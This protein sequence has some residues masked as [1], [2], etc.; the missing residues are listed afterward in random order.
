MKR[1]FF[2]FGIVLAIQLLSFEGFGQMTIRK[3]VIDPGH[4]G[5]DPGA[6]GRNSREKDIVLAVALKTGAYIEQYLDDVEV[7][8]T[9]TTDKFVELYRRAQIANESKA[10]L[11]ISIHC[12]SSRS[13]H[14]AGAETFVM[15]LHRTQQNLEVAKTENAAILKEEN[16]SDMYEG[17]DPAQDEDYV[18][19]SLFQNAFLDHSLDM[20]MRVQN[21]FR[22][23]V[24]RT[25]RGVKQ[26]G[27]WVLYKTA[28]PGIL[29]ELGFLSNPYE[30][31]FLMSEEGKVYLASAIF[32]AFRDYKVAFESD[33]LQIKPL[34]SE[35]NEKE[36]EL[37]F[38]VQFF[39]SK[40]QKDIFSKKFKDISDVRVYYHNGLYKY[41]SGN[42]TRMEDV[43][44][45]K[46]ELK[47]KGLD[48]V[49][50][51]AFY[52]EERISLDEANKLLQE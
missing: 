3:V 4:G 7:I 15:G 28:M 35:I 17:F 29:V 31:K 36:K 34:L 21:Q 22:D 13:S 1:I 16:Y 12:N 52:G 45:L 39:S 32:R 6:L 47:A 27:F 33:A 18:T 26:A 44:R 11:F 2:F 50:I 25:D 9:R 14:P 8:Y 51:V 37:F 48:D 41:T 10:D 5:K 46:N 49:F 38:R 40:K 24:G 19:L 20:A 43:V 30:E 23:R 42:E